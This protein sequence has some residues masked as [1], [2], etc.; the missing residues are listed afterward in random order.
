MEDTLDLGYLF[1]VLKKHLLFVVLIGIIAA[2][3]G[4]SVSNFLIP[5][6]YESR[7]LL[8]IENNQQTSEAVNINDINAAQKLVNTCQI[9]FKSYTV[10]D[11]LIANLDLPY[12]KEELDDMITASSVNGTEVMELVVECGDPIEAQTI[13]NELVTLSTDEFIRVVKSGS[14]EV[15]DLG[16][17]NTDPS[18]P[19][20]LIITA[21][22]LIM[23]VAVS[24]RKS[25]V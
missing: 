20:V 25:V 19:N 18:Y 5:K 17:V 23:G 11:S 2:A 22:C 14:V 21:V 15:I 16:E 3:A 4:F 13:V 9:I 7:A 24:D 1:G 6:K 12:T 10:M 8:Y